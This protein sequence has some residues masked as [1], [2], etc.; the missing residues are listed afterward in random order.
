[1]TCWINSITGWQCWGCGG[2]RAFHQLLHG[3]F[4]EALQFNALVFPVLIILSY[5]LMAE[6]FHPRPSYIF[7][8]KRNIQIITLILVISFTLLRNLI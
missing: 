8:R 3:N 7:L 1:M 4:R 6:L 5:T 2:Q